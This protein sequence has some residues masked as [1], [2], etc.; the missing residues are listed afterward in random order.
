MDI[1]RQLLLICFLLNKA[2][3]VSMVWACTIITTMDSLALDLVL[4]LELVFL[5]K[6]PSPIST[7][8]TSLL[9][10]QAYTEAIQDLRLLQV[11]LLEV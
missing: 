9:R 3:V 2:T 11:M 1:I 7:S 10:H 4:Y 8:S 5:H 6:N